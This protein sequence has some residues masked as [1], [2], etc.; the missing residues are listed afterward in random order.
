[1]NGS[2]A[3]HSAYRKNGEGC[4][5]LSLSLSLSGLS[6]FLIEIVAALRRPSTGCG[7]DI[8]QTFETIVLLG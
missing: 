8:E 7:W 2:A 5:C 1:M 4:D 3:A 6:G